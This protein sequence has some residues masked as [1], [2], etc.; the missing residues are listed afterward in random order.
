MTFTPDQQNPA[1][2]TRRQAQLNAI[3]AKPLAINKDGKVVT[4]VTFQ[5]PGSYMLQFMGHDGGLAGYENLTV[6]VLP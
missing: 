6:T 5:D 3:D 4:T 2:R 1:L